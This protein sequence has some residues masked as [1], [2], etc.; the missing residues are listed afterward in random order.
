VGERFAGCR[1]SLLLVPSNGLPLL[2]NKQQKLH[3][4]APKRIIGR[5]LHLP[6]LVKVRSDCVD[7]ILKVARV[8]RHC[9]L[10]L[11]DPLLLK[12]SKDAGRV[13]PICQTH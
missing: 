12:V 7:S 4:F 13:R 1:H 8:V 3:T 10:K 5:R 11:F 6:F 2:L 9:R